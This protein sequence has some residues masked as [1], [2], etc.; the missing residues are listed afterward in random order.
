L[1]EDGYRLNDSKDP[2]DAM[3]QQAILKHLA[4]EPQLKLGRALGEA[5]LATAMI[6]ISDGL[7]TDLSHILDES[8]CG[9]IIHS[10]NI[11]IAASLFS[12][13]SEIDR[14]RLAL[15]GGEEYELLFTA[16]PES[17]R[18]VAELS[19][20]L[21]ATITTVG[22]II[23]GKGLQLERAAQLETIL[24]SGFEHII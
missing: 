10:G 6:D 24:P 14:L 3:R 23:E 5:R 8:G 4:P 21:G 16:R 22:E 18:Q 1:L 13:A 11:P 2:T 20:A 19:D 15:H 12:L 17:Q 9:A 7:T